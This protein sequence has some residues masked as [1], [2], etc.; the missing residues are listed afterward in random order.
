MAIRVG[1]STRALPRGIV[2]VGGGD[3]TRVGG[4]NVTA[5]NL[6]RARAARD[7]RETGATR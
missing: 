2:P 4:G 6:R 7:L 1:G 5:S 3:C